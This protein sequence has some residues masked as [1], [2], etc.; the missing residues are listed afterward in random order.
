MLCVFPRVADPDGARLQEH[1]VNVALVGTLG[2][3]RCV[4]LSE[5]QL[6]SGHFLCSRKG[7]W[8]LLTP[9]SLVL[10]DLE[11][12]VAYWNLVLSGRF[13]FLDLWNTFLLVSVFLPAVPVWGSAG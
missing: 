2:Q 10:P 8:D 3:G 12:A 7:N 1:C 13:K 6:R 9:L 5:Y 11:M 4:V